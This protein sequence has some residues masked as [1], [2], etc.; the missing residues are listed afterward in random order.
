MGYESRIYVVK[1][2]TILDTFYNGSKKRYAELIASVNMCKCIGLL[3]IFKN[4]TDCF[5]YADDG[6]TQII[7]DS[8]DDPLKETD[9]KTVVDWLNAEIAHGNDYR[10]LPVL[11]GVLKPFAD[12]EVWDDGGIVVLHYGY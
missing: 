6:N 12:K 11:L 4:E 8:Y 10:R 9:V 7:E 5:I 1:K 3:D 2:S